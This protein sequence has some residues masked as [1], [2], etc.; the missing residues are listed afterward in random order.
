M[1]TSPQCSRETGHCL[2]NCLE[3]WWGDWCERKCSEGCEDSSCYFW[4]GSCYKGC[5][6]GWAGDSCDTRCPVGC[7]SDTC[8]RYGSHKCTQGCQRGVHGHHCDKQCNRHCRHQDCFYDHGM[9]STVCRQ[10]CVDGWMSLDC[11]MRCPGNCEACSQET[12]ECSRCKPGY[13]GSDCTSHCSV[14]C[15]NKTCDRGDGRCSGCIHGYYGNTCDTGCG[16]DCMRCLQVDD[17]CGCREEC[18]TMCLQHHQQGRA[19]SSITE[20]SSDDPPVIAS[21]GTSGATT[22]RP[23]L[24]SSSGCVTCP[25]PADYR[26]RDTRLCCCVGLCSSGLE[27]PYGSQSFVFSCDI[28]DLGMD[29]TYMLVA[30]FCV[31]GLRGVLLAICCDHCEGQPTDADCQICRNR[32][33][34]CSEALQETTLVCTD[35]CIDGKKGIYCQ[36]DCLSTCS[37]CERYGSVCLQCKDALSYGKKCDKRCPPNCKGGCA[38]ENGICTTCALGFRGARCET[39]CRPGCEVCPRYTDGCFTCLSDRYYGKDC[40]FPC[41]QNCLQCKKDTGDCTECVHGY[42]GKQCTEHVQKLDPNTVLI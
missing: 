12:G 15:S 20:G 1:V 39:P 32:T 26:L 40:R 19:V 6:D 8:E 34:T 3:G 5:R 27:H 29:M 28:D 23:I 4:D 9:K 24:D 11:K 36:E 41:P 18:H 16:A 22:S 38:K 30:F 14:T 10:G 42:S 33:R 7:H 25:W 35:G 17:G 37:K 31:S 2:E 21:R 13:W